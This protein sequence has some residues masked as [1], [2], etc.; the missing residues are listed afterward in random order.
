MAPEESVA[1]FEV[2][3]PESILTKADISDGSKATELLFGVYAKIAD[4]ADGSLD[5][6]EEYKF[7]TSGVGTRVD[8]LKFTAQV[9]LVK[10][11]DYK[12]A[13]WAQAPVAAGET[14]PYAIDWNA[15]TVTADYTFDANAEERDAFYFC[16]EFTYVPLGEPYK[17]KLYRPMAQINFGSVEED[18]EALK[19]FLEDMTYGLESTITVAGVHDVLDLLTGATSSSGKDV[20]FVM[21]P[22]FCGKGTGT[23]IT[24][25]VKDEAGVKQS[26]AYA[27]M[28]YI[29]APESKDRLLMDKLTA[30]FE[31]SKGVITLEVLNVPYQRNHRTNILGYLFTEMLVADIL[32][33]PIYDGDNN[34]DQAGNTLY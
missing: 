5:G 28:N 1:V 15:A 9:N 14:A 11:V 4:S 22:A 7:V 3:M 27:G 18:F 17:V 23:E 31:H 13:F 16:D 10:N 6:T 29:F 26:Y 2:Q 19:P 32:V 8:D 25:D 24:L 21:A 12:V 34:L 20:A 33:V 30:S